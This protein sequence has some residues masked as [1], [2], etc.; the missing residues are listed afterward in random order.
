M[1]DCN[2]SAE[3]TV[4]LDDLADLEAHIYDQVSRGLFTPST[5]QL[6]SEDTVLRKALSMLLRIFGEPVP[7][8][9][10]PG[11]RDF[12]GGPAHNDDYLPQQYS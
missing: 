11:K 12:A 2:E 7:A 3:S 9:C 10:I 6:I 1:C 5:R 4:E 8:S